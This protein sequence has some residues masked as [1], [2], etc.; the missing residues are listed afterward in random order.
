MK[1]H[2]SVLLGVVWGALGFL[3][4]Y[5]SPWV[6]AFYLGILLS[7]ILRYKLDN[8]SHGIGA[9]IILAGIILT[10]P[11]SVPQLVIAGVTFVLFAIFGILS[12]S[13]ILKP[14][15]F[16]E[17]NIY[18]FIFLIIFSFWHSEVW[19]VVLAL[20]ANVI[21]YHSVKIYWRNK[22]FKIT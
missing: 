13:K 7:W 12:R 2:L 6:G 1:K 3:I 8:Y 11:Y 5:M 20:I 22:T 16:L 19:L 18:S 15:W 17:Y 10:Q 14:G 4:V 9:T 21:G